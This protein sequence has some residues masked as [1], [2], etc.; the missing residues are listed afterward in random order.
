MFLEPSTGPLIEPLSGRRWEPAE[1][2]RQIRARAAAYR[3]RGLRRGDRV[4][5]GFGNRLE[6][7]A[8]LLAVWQFGGCAVPLDARLTRFE[9]ETL[10]RAAKPRAYLG[11][12]DTDPLLAAGLRELGTE[13]IDS[14]SA[15]REGDAESE[16]APDLFLD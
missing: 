3:S 15:A 13:I 2:S 9:I 4:F 1:I 5:L 7:F 10:T 12:G 16:G 6:F 8:D 14:S 11:L